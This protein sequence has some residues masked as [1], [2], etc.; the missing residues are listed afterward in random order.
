MTDARS[1]GDGRDPNA[2]VVYTCWPFGGWLCGVAT[3]A[4]GVLLLADH[5]LSA[6]PEVLW[7][8]GL[9]VVGAVVALRARNEPAW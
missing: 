3:M 9:I 6:A 5:Y 8:I 4:I 7:G 1:M 2:P